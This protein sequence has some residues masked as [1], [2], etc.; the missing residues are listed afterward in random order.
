MA[1]SLHGLNKRSIYT[2]F[3]MCKI[4][5]EEAQHTCVFKF[6]ITRQHIWNLQYIFW[7]FKDWSKHPLDLIFTSLSQ[8]A[9]KIVMLALLVLSIGN[10]LSK[11]RPLIVV[12]LLRPKV[13]VLLYS[14]DP[15]L[16]FFP[17]SETGNTL[18]LTTSLVVGWHQLMRGF[19]CQH[20]SPLF[21]HI[22]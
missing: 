12:I 18:P 11:S 1:N 20:T 3:E 7:A 16:S 21:T 6:F 22:V 8:Q 10:S 15:S 14:I 4:N 2:L 13:C 17:L 9:N 19:S 5:T